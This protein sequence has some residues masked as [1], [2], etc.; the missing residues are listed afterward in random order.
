[1]TPIL[2]TGISVLVS[3][4][5]N[6]PPHDGLT[7]Q[8]LFPG[9]FG[10]RLYFFISYFFS[11]FSRE[12]TVSRQLEN[13]NCNCTRTG[14]P[15]TKTESDAVDKGGRVRD[16]SWLSVT[17]VDYIFLSAVISGLLV[18]ASR[19]PTYR[20]HQFL[21]SLSDSAFCFGLV[22][23]PT[24]GFT[25][26]VRSSSGV[27]SPQHISAAAWVYIGG[28]NKK[29]SSGSDWLGDLALVIWLPFSVVEKRKQAGSPFK[30]AN[31]LFCAKVATLKRNWRP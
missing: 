3:P 19:P 7:L 21:L 16:Q 20:V 24:L 5:L 6:P 31:A 14:C 10:R 17:A 12:W 30:A 23:A 8:P 15:H 27:P 4:F 29:F 18:S 13:S 9:K 25:G 11:A 22:L 2:N 1:M 28:R 26:L